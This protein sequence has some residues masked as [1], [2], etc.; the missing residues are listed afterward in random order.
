MDDPVLFM[1]GV[2]A[3][4]RLWEKQEHLRDTTRFLSHRATRAA[5]RFAA[6]DDRLHLEPR[7]LDEERL[8]E[9]RKDHE[10][11]RENEELL[12]KEAV[13]EKKRY[14]GKNWKMLLLGWRT[15][16]LET[17]VKR[18]TSRLATATPRN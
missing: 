7:E 15:P 6:L 8:I 4:Q 11:F 14:N 2:G 5:S 3:V 16:R 18:K 12:D 10:K 1:H 9:A 13:N 17:A